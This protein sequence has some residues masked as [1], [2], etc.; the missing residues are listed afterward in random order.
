MV[1]DCRCYHSCYSH[2]VEKQSGAVGI[3]NN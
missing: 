3:V 2:H 1:R